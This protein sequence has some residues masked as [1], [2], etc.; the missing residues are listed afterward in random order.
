[1]NQQSVRNLIMPS[2]R[3]V[4]LA[5][6]LS[7]LIFLALYSNLI[8][9]RFFSHSFL[10]DSNLHQISLQPIS[11]LSSLRGAGTVTII[12]FYSIV[13]L[14]VYLIFL[15]IINVLTEARNEVVIETAYTN[16]GTVWQRFRKPGLQSLA[17]IGLFMLL[18]VTGFVTVPL[19]LQLFGFFLTHASTWVGWLAVIGGVTGQAANIYL[20]LL[21][22]RL[23]FM[24]D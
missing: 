15:G 1:M 8:F 6:I 13:G 12:V 14:V 10:S 3:Q 16:R 2:L 19:W 17:A 22:S 20:L 21:V 18:A 5:L 7:L 11:R 9:T 24:I 4:L 23:V